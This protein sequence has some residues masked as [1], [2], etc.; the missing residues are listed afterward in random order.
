MNY[1]DLQKARRRILA[2]SVLT[3]KDEKRLATLTN[4]LEKMSGA[5][6]FYDLSPDERL[7]EARRIL[8]K[9]L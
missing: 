1:D 9:T 2:K 5:V 4:Q 6:S 7:R 8:G 3:P